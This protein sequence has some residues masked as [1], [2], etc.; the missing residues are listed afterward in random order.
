MCACI[1]IYMY[2][3]VFFV[4]SLFLVSFSSFSL[5]PSFPSFP[6]P[7]RLPLS[8]VL[9]LAKINLRNYDPPSELSHRSLFC[10]PFDSPFSYV[11]MGLLPSLFEQNNLLVVINIILESPMFCGS[12]MA[13]TQMIVLVV[14]GTFS[15]PN[16]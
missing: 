4:L 10:L 15:K 13:P 14:E 3:Y 11:H 7:L 5:C 1:H 6:S 9:S 2:V 8:L 12:Y 16:L